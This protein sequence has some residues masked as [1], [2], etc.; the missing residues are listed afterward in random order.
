MAKV[1]SFLACNLLVIVSWLMLVL[2]HDGFS[3]F[4]YL[5]SKFDDDIVIIYIIGGTFLYFI[6]GDFFTGIFNNWLYKREITNE[7]KKQELQ[8]IRE[9][10][11]E[12]EIKRRE[13]EIEFDHLQRI[14]MLQANIDQGKLNALQDMQNNLKSQKMSDLDTL[15][16][17][18]E[19]M[20]RG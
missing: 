1:L 8:R 3:S 9:Q 16:Q 6:F 18:I 4:L 19:S 7:Y 5:L 15:R 2:F 17:Q 13:L 10:D 14:M 11:R 12:I 20:K